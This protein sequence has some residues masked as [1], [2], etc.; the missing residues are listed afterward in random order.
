ML[1]EKTSRAI[2]TR[3]LNSLYVDVLQ[4]TPF[5]VEE[6]EGIEA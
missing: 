6:A 3:S 1:I 2:F 4:I 5:F